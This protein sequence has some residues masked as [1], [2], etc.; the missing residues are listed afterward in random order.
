MK[1]KLFE[2]EATQKK[3]YLRDVLEIKKYNSV[4]NLVYMGTN[5]MVIHYSNISLVALGYL[6]KGL[7]GTVLAPV[8]PRHKA[9]C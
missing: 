9:P 1:D 4:F 5:F 2:Y 7:Y 3:Q 6:K 8:S